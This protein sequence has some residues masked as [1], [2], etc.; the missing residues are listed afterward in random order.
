[1]Y[2]GSLQVLTLTVLLNNIFRTQ[3]K[4]TAAILFIKVGTNLHNIPIL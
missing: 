2:Y 3:L 1:M 4:G